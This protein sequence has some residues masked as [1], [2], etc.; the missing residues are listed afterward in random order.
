VRGDEVN[1]LRTGAN[2]GWPNRTSGTYRNADYRPPDVAGPFP[3][4]AW[5]RP[6]RTVARTGMVVYSVSASPQWRG[7]LLLAGLSRG[8]LMRLDV[9]ENRIV[10]AEYLLEE[11]LT[12]LSN[13][14]QARNGTLY[15]LTNEPADRLLRVERLNP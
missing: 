4:P 7:D 11:R 9:E 10:R 5:T 2:F 12:R 3:D 6:D 8:Y 15:L 13:V 14:K 1:L